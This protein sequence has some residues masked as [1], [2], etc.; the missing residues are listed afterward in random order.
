[1]SLFLFWMTIVTGAIAGFFGGALGQSG[2]ETMLPLLLLFGIV[3][4]F[5]TAAGTVL[6]AI[7]PPISALAVWQYYKRGQ[8]N[9]FI[10]FWLFIAYFIAAFF[11]AYVTKEVSN[12]QLEL[13]TAVYFLLISLFFFWN[14][15]TGTYGEENGIH[16]VSHTSGFRTLVR[17]RM[18][19]G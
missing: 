5:K 15:F 2:S 8:V 4:D 13:V 14:A 12:R 3:P 7:V 16:H 11:G 9:L 17:Q 10:S 1:M 6:L 18:Q 19:K